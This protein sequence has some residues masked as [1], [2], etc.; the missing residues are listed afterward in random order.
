MM[1]LDEIRSAPVRLEVA[2]EA[3]AQV[4]IRLADQLDTRKHLDQRAGVLFAG[5]VAITLALLV[6]AADSLSGRGLNAVGAAMF[7]AGLLFAIG[8]SLFAGA[9]GAAEYGNPGSLPEAWLRADILS[10][11]DS[12]LATLIA[13]QVHF[14]DVSLK[15]GKASN[16]R[17]V[18]LLSAGIGAGFAAVCV[19]PAVFVAFGGA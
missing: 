19:A 7:A 14:S 5:Y 12:G 9:M 15:A 4:S 13:Y 10:T 2:R 17:K 11:D 3:Y 1:S 18:A 6:G 8:A 16:A